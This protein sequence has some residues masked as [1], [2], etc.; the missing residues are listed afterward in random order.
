MS[1]GKHKPQ[2]RED[3][4]TGHLDWFHHGLSF[5]ELSDKQTAAGL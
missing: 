2:Q 3:E 5:G 4:D 1:R